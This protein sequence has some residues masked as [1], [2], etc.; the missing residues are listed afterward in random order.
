MLYFEYIVIYFIIYLIINIVIEVFMSAI[1]SGSSAFTASG[2]VTSLASAAPRS[3][4]NWRDRPAALQSRIDSAFA[5]MSKD[6]SS[7]WSLYNGSEGSSGYGLCEVNEY[8]L[9]ESIVRK[10]PE[11]Q[12]DFYA[13][14]IGCANFQWGIR[15]AEHFDG[16]TDLPRA[17][18]LHIINVRGEPHLGDRV[19]ET[20][21]CKL[22]KLGAF[23]VEEL[24]D[25]FKANGLDLENKVDLVVSRYTFRHLADPVG[26]FT[27]VYDHLRPGSGILSMDGFFFLEEGDAKSSYSEDY[28]AKMIRLFSDTKARFISRDHTVGGSLSH[29]MLQRSDASKCELPMKYEGV[30]FDAPVGSNESSCMTVFSRE[31]QETDHYE[32]ICFS[33]LEGVKPGMKIEDFIRGDKGL[34]ERLKRDH[35]IKSG[36]IAPLYASELPSSLPAVHSAVIAGDKVAFYAALDAGHDIDESDLSG[37]TALH[38]AVENN[39]Y[40][41]F[42]ILLGARADAALPNGAGETILQIAARCDTDGRFIRKLL[43]LGLDVNYGRVKFGGSPLDKAERSGNIVAMGILLDAGAR[44]STWCKE[45][46][47]ANAKFASLHSH[48]ALKE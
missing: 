32:G 22:Y 3:P 26:T 48:P 10:A 28:D 31:P 20:S 40:E 19:I 13:L 15:L 17:I 43:S 30:C 41:L 44:V 8:S 37:C 27:Q 46:V 6:T 24:F 21:R 47:L 9:M 45:A 42:E 38:L 35:I 39:Q 33:P 2:G 16:I 36:G 25:Q 23:K 18:K 34:Y 7:H 14:D 29:L 1:S 12:T 11:D 4:L 5:S